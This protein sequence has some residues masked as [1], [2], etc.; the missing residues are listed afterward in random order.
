MELELQDISIEPETQTAFLKNELKP[1][2]LSVYLR[3][4]YSFLASLMGLGF[5]F[6]VSIGSLVFH[7]DCTSKLAIPTNTTVTSNFATSENF[8]SPFVD[9][10]LLTT[11]TCLG[12][13][14]YSLYTTIIFGAGLLVSI[15]Y[16]FIPKNLKWSIVV[17]N[18]FFALGFA[19][20][21]R[22]MSI[23]GLAI[24][25]RFLQGCG[26]A[27]MLCTMVIFITQNAPKKIMTFLT[28]L[29]PSFIAV[30]AFVDTL[31]GLIK[32]T[33]VHDYSY[34]LLGYALFF[35][36]LA[37]AFA[38]Y[39][40]SRPVLQTTESSPQTK[41]FLVRAKEN[42][43]GIA[44]IFLLHAGQQ[45]SLINGLFMYSYMIF[46]DSKDSGQWIAV[47]PKTGATLMTGINMISCLVSTFL[48]A[49]KV[50]EKVLYLI[51]H[52]GLVFCLTFL[53]IGYQQSLA[54][55]FF[56][57]LFSL[58][59]GPLVWSLSPSFFQSDFKNEGMALGTVINMF[60]SF[61]I[62]YFFKALEEYNLFQYFYTGAAII[63]LV[64]WLFLFKL[65]RISERLRKS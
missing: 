40:N 33:G 36:S 62:P 27:L 25:A 15:I 48:C 51:S 49:M 45:F 17:S 58:G 44:I 1:Q 34:V 53:G 3:G 23:P 11:D 29:G 38:F 28:I 20:N 24:F 50:N 39:P 9:G 6:A 35:L 54:A 7:W 10:H 13:Y 46:A 2:K 26:S 65:M 12:P 5:G 61:L 19:M 64:F 56:V 63:M 52:A 32:F 47:S 22:A 4:F 59:V 14:V 60:F 43:R 16:F 8:T 31:F 21:F 30:G 18:L 55:L 42:L 57:F 41:P 37:I